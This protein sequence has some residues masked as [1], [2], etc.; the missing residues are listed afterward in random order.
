MNRENNNFQTRQSFTRQNK[1]KADYKAPP[2]AQ[3]AFPPQPTAKQQDEAR[4][5]PKYLVKKEQ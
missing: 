4:Q 3:N 2:K 5:S 1:T